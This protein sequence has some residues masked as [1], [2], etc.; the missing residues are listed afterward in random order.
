[1][2]VFHL[3]N[4]CAL[5]FCL[6]GWLVFVVVVIWPDHR[7]IGWAEKPGGAAHF[8][9]DSSFLAVVFN[10]FVHIRKR[11]WLQKLWVDL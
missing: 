9:A 1:M 11:P 3:P 5:G 6:F 4:A 2:S 10:A 7:Y 8:L